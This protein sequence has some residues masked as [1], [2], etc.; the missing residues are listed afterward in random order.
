MAEWWAGAK[1]LKIERSRVWLPPSKYRNK[2]ASNQA[3][4]LVAHFNP[5]P[6]RRGISMNSTIR[7]P[8]QKIRIEDSDFSLDKARPQFAAAIGAQID[9]DDASDDFIKKKMHANIR[10]SSTDSMTG[11]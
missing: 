4:Y 1:A 6:D 10:S 3:S 8:V 5:V 7:P 2:E 9:R 11:F